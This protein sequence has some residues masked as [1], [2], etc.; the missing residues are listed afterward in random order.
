M[1]LLFW[2]T[3]YLIGLV[4]AQYGH[5]GVSIG[6]VSGCQSLGPSYKMCNV[7]KGVSQPQPHI[8]KCNNT[9]KFRYDAYL[10]ISELLLLSYVVG[11]DGERCDFFRLSWDILGI[12]FL[13]KERCINV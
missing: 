11:V 3:S 12:K 10:T 13:L 8:N 7:T 2:I 6:D 5:S 1:S 9:E 4:S